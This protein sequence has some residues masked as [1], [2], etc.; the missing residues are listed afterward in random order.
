PLPEDL[1]GVDGAPVEVL[2][3]GEL[4]ALVSSAPTDRPLGNRDDLFAHEK[5]VDA[6]ARLGTVLPVRFG[7]V[8]ESDGVIDELLAPH[9]EELT[10]ALAELDGQV[11]YTVK[12]R[13]VRE[14]VLREI[15]DGDPEI[16]ELNAQVRDRPDEEVYQERVRLGELVVNELDARRQA[17]GSQLHERLAA[18]A[19]AAVARSSSDPEEALNSAFLIPRQRTAEFE[20]AVEKV[21]AET[22]ERVKFTLGGPL[23]P[24]DFAGTRE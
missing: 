3:H 18:L 16:A 10:A 15:V 9:V 19:T 7:S 20:D 23:A 17:E 24:Y 5:V 21:A 1:T 14:V 6:I 8:V 4:A 12:G 13:Y 22:G 2:A 11:Q